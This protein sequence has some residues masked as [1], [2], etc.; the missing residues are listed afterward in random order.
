MPGN[1][2]MP[3]DTP[4]YIHLR[5]HSAYSLLEGALPVKLLAKLAAKD[6]QPALAI[7]DRNNLFGAL[8]ASESFAGSGIQPITGCTLA[9]AEPKT[10][11]GGGTKRNGN[12]NSPIAED[13]SSVDGA[14]RLAGNCAE[15]G[16]MLEFEGGC[17][18]CRGCGYSRC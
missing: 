11:A 12:G 13:W 18:V 8:E 17:V 14:E 4:G 5:V 3:S 7:T 2:S 1:K 10:E 16:G 15:C 9:V 6:A